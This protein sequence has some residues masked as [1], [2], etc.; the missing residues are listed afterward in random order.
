MWLA[1]FVKKK[2]KQIKEIF[3]IHVMKAYRAVELQL[4]WFLTSELHVSVWSNLTAGQF[5]PG[6]GTPVRIE[7]ETG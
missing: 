7:C 2:Y 1:R 4:H 3:T 6:E 5:L